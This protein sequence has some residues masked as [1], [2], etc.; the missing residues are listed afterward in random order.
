VLV[1]LVLLAVAGCQKNRSGAR[2]VDSVAGAPSTTVGQQAHQPAEAA[3]ACTA[4]TTTAL[5]KG[6]FAALSSERLS[7]VD[8]FFPPASRFL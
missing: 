8:A 5:V 7:D 4:T 3:S 2:M 6:F 1:G